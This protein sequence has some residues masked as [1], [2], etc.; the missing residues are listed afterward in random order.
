MK[1]N[2]AVFFFLIFVY[3]F[4]YAMGNTLPIFSANALEEGGMEDKL[5]ENIIDQIENLDLDEL[6]NYIDNLQG[7]TKQNVAQRLLDYIR[8]EDFDYVHLG[9][10]LTNVLFKKCREMFPAFACIIAVTLLSGLISS[11][12]SGS[13]AK[14]SS[15]II[16]FISYVCALIP[17]LSVLTECI[18]VSKNCITDMQTQMQL[19]FPIMLTLIAASGGS[20]T[21]GVSSPAVAFFSSTIVNVINSIVLPFTVVILALSIAGNFSNELNIGKFSAFFKSINKW[22]IG[23]CVS[24]FGLFF[25]LQGIT[26]S[27]YDGIVRRA[28][29]YAI[30]NGVP[31]IGGFLSGGFDLAVAGGILIKNSLGSMSIFL[32]IFV[33]FEPLV[34]LI[35]VNILLRFSAAVTQPF[36]DSRISN[37][38]ASTADNL[39]YCTASLLFTA[40]MYFLSI[41]ILISS[42][43]ALL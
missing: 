30:G 39:N 5:N 16:Y 35:C 34:L 38:L 24:V 20:V 43:E 21:V 31:I 13:I 29:K 4:I 6:Q 15:T 18:L 2:K 27:T 23:I 26:S 41:I 12:N 8:G 17:L 10:E 11:L 19:F 42:T 36:G 14:A 33:L 9:E 40:F 1:K 37:F 3:L 25:T 32:M 28:A 22:I 7:F